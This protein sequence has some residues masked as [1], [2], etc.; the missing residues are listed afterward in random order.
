MGLGAGGLAQL[1][2][3]S[4][5]DS[6]EAEGLARS[7][8]WRLANFGIGAVAVTAARTLT[9]P[10]R[11]VHVQLL[12]D[13]IKGR[14]SS[15]LG[16]TR[17]IWRR[18]GVR[19]FLH[20]NLSA[21]VRTAVY[22]GVKLATWTSLRLFLEDTTGRMSNYRKAVLAGVFSAAVAVVA[23]LPMEVLETRM[24]AA[25]RCDPE[26]VDRRRLIGVPFGRRYWRL[27]QGL[28][29]D[30]AEQQGGKAKDTLEYLYMSWKPALANQLLQELVLHTTQELLFMVE[31]KPAVRKYMIRV[32]DETR[33]LVKDCLVSFI[34]RVAC[35]PLI[36]IE[37]RMELTNKGF[38][39][40]LLAQLWVV[41]YFC[42][43]HLI[44]SGV[45]SILDRLE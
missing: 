14:K 22:S 4:A 39:A 43:Y 11:N 23:T 15:V 3:E 18:D 2:H 26:S 37:Y 45:Y 20:G 27:L 41:P 17:D 6:V 8:S 29:S 16:T 10:L 1:R 44:M 13:Q 24:I 21:C 25:M 12:L 28:R 33:Q 36:N 9:S 31:S 40:G 5:R 35:L 38:Y 7:T 42:S 30:L 34:A 19:G 32:G